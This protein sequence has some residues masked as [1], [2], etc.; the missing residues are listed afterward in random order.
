MHLVEALAETTCLDGSLWPVTRGAQVVSASEKVDVFQRR[1]ASLWGLANVIAIEQPGLATRVIDLDPAI[2]N[3]DAT[4][5]FSELA[6]G[7]NTRIARVVDN[8][9]PLESKII[10]IRLMCELILMVMRRSRHR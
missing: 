2:G 3:D 4:A 8:D 5:L 1:D 7:R 9:G 10:V 6:T